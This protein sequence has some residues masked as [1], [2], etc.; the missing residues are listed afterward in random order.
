MVIDHTAWG[1]LDFHTPLAQFLHVCGRLTVPIMCFFIAE[2]FRKT[3]NLKKYIGRMATFAVITIIPFYIFFHEEYDYRQ[4]IIFDLLLGLLMLTVLEKSNFAKWLKILLV[5][6]L[7]VVSMTIGGWVVAPQ[8]FIL[9]FYYGRTFRE[10]AK[11]FILTDVVMVAFLV[12]AICLNQKYH[13]SGYDWVWWDKFYL[14]GFMFALPLLY[15]YNGEK[16]KDVLGR[17]FFY[18]FY[19]MHF[20]VLSGIK[21]LT[22]TKVSLY[23]M[24]LSV[25]IIVLAAA[26]ALVIMTILTKPS[27][28]QGG[29]LLLEVSASLYIVGF[30]LEILG[31]TADGY[32]LAC[33]VQYFGE[34][35]AFIA[36]LIVVSRIC[37]SDIP[38]FVYALHIVVSIALIYA[39]MTTRE[40]GFF[41]SYLGVNT[42]GAFARPEIVHSTGFYL[43]FA[44]ICV[45]CI[46]AA[47]LGIKTF[48][49][50][51][52]IDKK[53]VRFIFL[54]LLSCWAPYGMTKLGMTAGYEVPAVGIMAATVFLYIS[55]FRYG[56]LDSV[57]LAS[58]NALDHAHE[59]I[60]VLD[61]QY[62]I[63]YHNKMV[64]DVL[65]E[66]D[67]NVDIRR[68]DRMRG[69]LEDTIDHINVGNEIYEFQV[70]PLTEKGYVQGLMIWILNATEHYAN[71]EKISDAANRDPLTGLYNRT[72]FKEMVDADVD[73]GRNGCFV[74]MDMDNFKRVNDAY[75]HQ[76]GDSVLKNLAGIL[77][78]FPESKL[79]A[80]RVGGDE[81]CAYFRD[82]TDKDQI[83][84]EIEHILSDF[85][86]TFREADEV[87][88]SISFGVYINDRSAGTLKDCS[89]MYSAA[90]AKLYEAKQS[91]KNTYRM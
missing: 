74:M 38:P 69:V 50:G 73:D 63:I 4:N 5:A 25:H 32:Y 9:A 34:Y 2:G 23:S 77:A 55:F 67:H 40:T 47:A 64:D 13:F 17:Y 59:G 65:G 82:M 10:K 12:V 44:Y 49:K 33:L 89:G 11:W 8:L 31:V 19:P 30:I 88:C 20:L 87:K 66:L 81:F 6:L 52:G 14:L 84:A 83:A 91:G 46:E 22:V 45:V 79:F 76:R 75:G 60:I 28:G 39:L 78:E 24:Y 58:E 57:I 21:A 35:M 71:I 29:I 62:H 90:D 16:G 18:I 3:R 48:R 86:M 42:S 37:R 68:D 70:E 7:F 56:T 43:S 85:A 61:T 26:L 80:C 15:C 1:F 54:A 36:F 41:Y 51:T 72:C 27:R 53:R